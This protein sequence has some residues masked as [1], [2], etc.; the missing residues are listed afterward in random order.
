MLLRICNL[1]EFIE[2]AKGRNVI[3]FGAGSYLSKVCSN[4]PEIHLERHISYITDSNSEIWENVKTINDAEIPVVPPD[5]LFANIKKG[6]ILLI[7]TGYAYAPKIYEILENRSELKNTECYLTSFLF[8]LQIFKTSYKNPPK[9]WRMNDKPVIPKKIHYTWFSGSKIPEHLQKYIESWRKFC[10]DYEIIEWNGK[11]YDFSKHPYM[12]ESYE[13]KKWGFIADY[14]RLDILYTQGGIYLDTDVELVRPLDDLLYNTAFC[15]FD[16]K[17]YINIGSGAGCVPGLKIIADLRDDYDDAVFINS[18]G[19]LNLKVAPIYQA[20]YLKKRGLDMTG[21]FQ[22]IEGMAVYPF[23]YFTPYH[24]M[25]IGRET[26]KT[27]AIHRYEGSWM[28][29]KTKDVKLDY[30]ELYKLALQNEA[31]IDL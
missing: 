1:A 27:Y 2:R 6:D 23:E 30:L 31:R 7:S 26:E 25:E 8:T 4:F 29:S 18:D 5:M 22:V 20:E 19:S 15:G 16:N 14:A 24:W 10:P 9:N 12:K 13:A 3:C 17:L 28:L 21:N 11:N